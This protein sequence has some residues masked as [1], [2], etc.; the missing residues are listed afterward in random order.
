MKNKISKLRYVKEVKIL[1]R[2]LTNNCEGFP[3]MWVGERGMVI[4]LID[5]KDIDTWQQKLCDEQ[6]ENTNFES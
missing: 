4:F 2:Y 3:Y 5:S 6:L 1:K